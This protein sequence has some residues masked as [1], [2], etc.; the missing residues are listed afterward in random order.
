MSAYDEGSIDAPILL[1]GEAPAS[2]EMRQN[3]PFVGQAG[4]LLDRL[5]QAAQIRRS[6]IRILN[7]FETPI[8][9]PRNDASKILSQD[10]TLLWTSAKGFTDAGREASRSCRVS[11]EQSQSNVRCPLGGPALHT[12]VDTRSISKW[13]GS[14]ISGVNGH[15]VIPTF[16][17]SYALQGEYQA[18]FIIAADL[19]RVKAESSSPEI[20]LDQRH[21]IIDPSFAEAMDYLR[22]AYEAPAIDT[23]IEMLN[24]SVDCF[25]VAV[26][27][28]EAISIPIIDAHFEPR[29]SPEEELAIWQSYARLIAA[30]HIRKLNQNLAF[31]LS[32]LLQLNHIIPSG[33]IDDCMVAFSIMN[34]FLKKSLG[35][36]SS[37]Y[38]RE[39]YYK[40]DGELHDSHTIDD[41]ARR[42]LY[43]AKD[44]VVA[45]ESMEKMQPEL[46]TKGYRTTYDMTMRLLPSLV[47][48]M[49]RGVRVNSE[50]L[51]ITRR[52]TEAKIAALLERMAPAFGRP[53]ITEAPKRAADKRAVEASGAL[54]IHSPAQL[55]QYFYGEKKFKPYIGKTGSASVDDMALSRLVR[56]EECLEAK[57]LQEY[58]R[59]S[60]LN[61]RYL[62][63]RFDVD[64]RMRCSYNIRGTVTGRLSSSKTISSG[65]MNMQNLPP[66]FRGFLIQDE[67]QEAAS[68]ETQV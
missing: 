35:L 1:I 61:T 9:K 54:N 12:T 65:G 30:P 3:R 52:E 21:L 8:K 41:F 46:D 18:R 4:Q 53:I 17:P 10:D 38:T 27:P 24:G 22:R 68:T 26:S 59:L 19:K 29:W 62:D 32:M 25:S 2:E 42:W 48:M 50:A 43:N 56:R 20:R 23:D 63:I 31:D 37:L 58:R 60:T 33:P 64:G 67:E 7:V 66:S 13:R 28:T 39:P 11:L 6:E 45:F 16:H 40:D 49:V 14:I 36:I 55:C 15:K 51:A 47:Y 5:L 34:P 57:L 44:A